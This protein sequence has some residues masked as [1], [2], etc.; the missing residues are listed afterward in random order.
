MRITAFDSP[1]TC[2]D[3]VEPFLEREEA[4]N[5]LLLGLLYLLQDAERTG[6][7]ASDCLMAAV[8]EEDGSPVLVLLLN[9]LNLIVAG[10]GAGV[11]DA[12]NQALAMLAASGREVPGVV[13]PPAAAERLACGWGDLRQLTPYVKMEQRIYRLDKV[14]PPAEAPGKLVQASAD[15]LELVAD[16]YARF[17]D[18]IDEPM[19]AGDAWKKAQA[20]IAS[21]SVYLWRDGGFVS[22]AKKAR[23]TRHGVVVS[24]VYTPPES[25]GK[26]YASNC[27]AALSQRLLDS[28]YRFCSLYTDLANPT[29]NAI[30]TRIGYR[31]VQ[32]SMLYR[33]R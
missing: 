17:A 25:R 6:A 22:M 12:A 23:A 2:L 15:E 1:Q 32:D 28:G 5:N 20:S 3:R 19:T 18:E 8:E 4:A 14:E 21:S 24:L 31:P 13:G 26:G 33:F 27:V 29:S 16:W 10:Q 9:A 11:P 30:Y 7:S